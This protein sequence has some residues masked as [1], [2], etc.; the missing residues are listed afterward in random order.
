MVSCLYFWA[1]FCWFVDEASGAADCSKD[2]TGVLFVF[3]KSEGAIPDGG[4]SWNHLT[5]HTDFLRLIN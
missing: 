3:L 2:I 5:Q 1:E 4:D